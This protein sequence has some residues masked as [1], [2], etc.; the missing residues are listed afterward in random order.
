MIN[1]HNDGMRMREGCNASILFGWALIRIK[2]HRACCTVHLVPRRLFGMVGLGYALLR[3]VK[4]PG[5]L[6]N[7]LAAAGLMRG[8]AAVR[9]IVPLTILNNR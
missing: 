1:I 7:P 4:R 5:H 2:L 6:P 8:P 9:D 3:Y